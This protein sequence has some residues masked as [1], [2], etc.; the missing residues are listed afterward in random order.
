[1]DW[2]YFCVSSNLSAENKTQM[3]IPESFAHGYVL[4]TDAAEVLYKPTDYWS[5]EHERC[6][7]WNDASLVINWPIHEKPVLSRKDAQGKLFAETEPFS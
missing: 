3:W 5:P 2:H 1:M 6:I 7:A 4:L